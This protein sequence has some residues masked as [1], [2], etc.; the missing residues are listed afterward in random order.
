MIGGELED[1]L[2]QADDGL[3]LTGLLDDYRLLEFPAVDYY[4]SLVMGLLST[5][6][7]GF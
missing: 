5:F 7:F 1:G 3:E 4:P 6:L 2:G